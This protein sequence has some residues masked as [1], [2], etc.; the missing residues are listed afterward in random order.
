MSREGQRR[1]LRRIERPDA[2]D[3]DWPVLDAHVPFELVEDVNG[4]KNVD[5]ST[6]T[7]TS[8]ARDDPVFVTA[9]VTDTS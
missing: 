2:A 7:R 4:E 3:H 9:K 6:W 5:K 8:E 1:G